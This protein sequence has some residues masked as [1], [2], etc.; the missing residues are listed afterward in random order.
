[1]YTG[2][3][4]NDTA[5]GWFRTGGLDPDTS[6]PAE[7]ERRRQLILRQIG[8]QGVDM[9][10]GMIRLALSTPSDTAI[11]PVQDVLGLG[12]EG[13]MNLP[14]S[15]AGNWEWRLGEDALDPAL[16]ARLLELTRAHGRA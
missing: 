13:R 10:W 7:I 14:A 16:A 11:I 2:T 9:H 5:Q 1:V 12:P 15:T 8:S 6:P 3:H 4:D